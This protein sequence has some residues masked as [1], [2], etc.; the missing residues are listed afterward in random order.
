MILT[1]A[2]ASHL[3]GLNPKFLLLWQHQMLGK[4]QCLHSDSYTDHLLCFNWSKRKAKPDTNVWHP[5]IEI[6]RADLTHVGAL[7]RL[8][9]WHHFKPTF[10]ALFDLGQDW[11]TLLKMCAQISVN[12]AVKFFHVWKHEFTGTIFPIITMIF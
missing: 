9:I 2:L 1:D 3:R 7:C 8:I 6:R 5:V 4:L 10:L 11:Q 12:V